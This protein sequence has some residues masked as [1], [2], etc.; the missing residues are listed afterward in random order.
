VNILVAYDWKGK[1]VC[2]ER[3]TEKETR[4]LL[5]TYHRLRAIV[6]FSSLTLSLSKSVKNN[7]MIHLF[8]NFVI[9]TS[10]I[11]LA[12]FLDPVFKAEDDGPWRLNEPLLLATFCYGIQLLELFFIELDFERF[13]QVIGNS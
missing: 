8:S 5:C 9:L 4:G 3:L 13:R 12:S 1:K 7:I 6:G 11:R 10:P 2:D